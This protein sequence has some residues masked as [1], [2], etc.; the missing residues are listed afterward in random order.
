MTLDWVE[1]SLFLMIASAEATDHYLDEQEIETILEKTNKLVLNCANKG[2]STTGKTVQEKFNKMIDWYNAIGDAAPQGLMDSEIAKEVQKV[3]NYLKDQP[4]FNQTFAQ[5][6][7]SDLVDVAKADGE[8]IENEKKS[9]NEIAK[10][11]GIKPWN[12]N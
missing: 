9:I 6:L 7:I 12:G 4:W 1:S 3:A 10:S 11:W 8:V 5:S 2:V